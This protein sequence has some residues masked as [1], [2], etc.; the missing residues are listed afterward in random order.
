VTGPDGNMYLVSET[1]NAAYEIY[2]PANV[3]A[4]HQT[5]LV[6][7]TLTPTDSTGKAL[8]APEKADPNLTNPWGISF[9]SSSPFWVSNQH[10]N[11]STLYAGDRT[12]PD[13]SI[14]PIT[15]NA[16]VVSV[17]GGPTGQI[18]NNTTD[19]KLKNGTTNS[20]FI[21]DTLGGSILAWGGTSP[22]ELEVTVTGASYT[23]LASGSNASGNFLYAANHNTGKIDVFDKTF[24][25]VS[26]TGSFEDPN[27]P[28]GSAY[29][30]FNIQNLGGT[31]YV[32]Y[33]KVV[34]VGGVTDREHDGIVD[35][36][37]TSGNFL[38]RVVTGGVN[39]PWGLALAPDNFGAFSG[40]LLVGNF[41]FGDG[42]I[43]AYQLDPVTGAGTFVGNLTDVSNNPIAVEGLWAIAFGNGGS[44]GDTN[45]LYLT[46]GIGRTGPNSFGASHGLFASIRVGPA[47]GPSSV[48]GDGGDG[49][50]APSAA[51]PPQAPGSP[52][53]VPAA[54]P[55]VGPVS[56]LPDTSSN[57]GGLGLGSG[58]VAV[59]LG[60]TSSGLGTSATASASST[61]PSPA[62]QPN[63][64][65][66]DQAFG[67]AQTS[68]DPL[69]PTASLSS[70][71]QADGLGVDLVW[72]DP[73]WNG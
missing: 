5:N 32:A 20:S 71:G 47:P 66:I 37:D 46:A 39:A 33:D 53:S 13:G 50:A 36:F 72:A 38:A 49:G 62:Q 59:L 45:A 54:P 51:V 8:A 29:H 34:T 15:V 3:A 19:F 17:P 48:G 10:S 25:K 6:A 43:N 69:P 11:T 9:S 40:D 64:N 4:F 23:G 7:D 28:P 27:L 52:G 56:V 14:S 21:F 22:A 73:L 70:S 1:K 26:L 35:A 30:A 2:N 24:T 42:K 41:G 57:P 55:E 67:S 44:G 61:V 58:V 16:L 18:R 31:L 60:S 68:G 12:Q 63:L 65:P